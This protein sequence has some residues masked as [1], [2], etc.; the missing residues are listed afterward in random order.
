MTMLRYK[1]TIFFIFII[2]HLVKTQDRG[3]T[4]R[5]DF[6]LIFAKSNIVN[7]NTLTNITLASTPATTPREL[8]STTPFDWYDMEFRLSNVGLRKIG[9]EFINSNNF[10]IKLKLDN[11][12]ISSISPYAFHKMSNLRYLD[13]SGN[14]IPKERLLSFVGSTKLQTLLINNNNDSRTVDVLID[15]IA[16]DNLQNLY[17]CNSQLKNL[18]VPYYRA[19]PNLNHLH[20]SNNS[21]SSSPVVFDNIPPMLTHLH[22]D[23]N[24]IDRVEPEKLRYVQKLIMDNNIITQVCY[25]NCRDASI[26]LKGAFSMQNL[27]LS[28]NKISEVT[29]DAFG[30]LNN[31]RYLD[32]SGNEIVNMHES[33]FNHTTRMIN[34]SLAHNKLT[35][36]PNICPM[37]Y[38]KSLDL[39]ENRI[40]IFFVFCRSEN[41]EYLYLSNN[42]ITTIENSAFV[43][44][45]YLKYVDLSGNQLKQLPQ[46]WV[47]PWNIQELHLERN[48]FTKI[49]DVSLIGIDSLKHVYL[50][51]NPM[52]T[53]KVESFKLL[54]VHLT[55]HIGK[56]RILDKKDDDN[57]SNNDNDD[58]DDDYDGDLF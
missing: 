24:L 6:N 57:N 41:L 39:T 53:F 36:M 26:S 44:L 29:S 19:T 5:P 32:L 18:Q 15:Y 17:L 25:E 31:L 10:I 12:E 40:M 34:L 14:K 33:T 27:S 50:D 56:V 46:K 2:L 45:E 22:V 23:N 21:I 38:L 51:E 58:D 43:N 30:D 35:A 16:L 54:P 4:F 37:R 48:N 9:E 28:R 52:D 3:R 1:L 11:N 20:L 47:L 7:G 13:L 55:V 42:H 49:D 8:P